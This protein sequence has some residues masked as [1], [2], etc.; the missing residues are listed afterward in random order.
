MRLISTA[1]A[2]V[3]LALCGASSPGAMT[4]KPAAVP[5]IVK[6]M[7]VWNAWVTVTL[8]GQRYVGYA[9]WTGSPDTVATADARTWVGV[10]SG[11]FYRILTVAEMRSATVTVE[12][13]DVVWGNGFWNPKATVTGMR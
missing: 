6:D 5:A 12:F 3:A 7:S 4:S 2:V 13:V 11:L 1:L 10:G 8:G 9:S